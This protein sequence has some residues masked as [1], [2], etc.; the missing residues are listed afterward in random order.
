M[1]RITLAQGG[2]G[3]F[4][5]EA[6]NNVLLKVTKAEYNETFGKITIVLMNEKG[7]YI[8]NK[9]QIRRNGKPNEGALRAF[10]FFARQCLN[11]YVEDID[12][13]E[14]LGSYVVADIVAYDSDREDDDGNPIIYYNL[15]K[16]YATDK[17]FGARPQPVV[18]E[19]S[20]W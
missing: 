16:V 4:I 7:E 18:E 1:S 12:P 10:S 13:Q 2:G 9:Y 5:S 17:T 19:N 3:G 6:G 8:T 11:H 20:S 15:D 14:L